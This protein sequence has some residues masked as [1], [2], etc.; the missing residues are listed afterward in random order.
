MRY[1]ILA[2]DYDGTL[3]ES[4]KV[5]PRTLAAL[6]RVRDSGR[7]LLLVTG[8]QIGDLQ[9]VFPELRLF[10]RIVAE[11]GALLY[12]PAT[13]EERLLTDPPPQEFV[14]VLESRGVV[15]LS[16]GRVVVATHKPH[17]VVALKVIRDM[18]LGLQI[19]FNKDAVMVLP[20]GVDKGS[21]L[22]H[23]LS[24]LRLSAHNT[25]G[26]GDA[27]NDHAFLNLCECAAA[28]GNAVPVIKKHV[29]FVVEGT[30]GEGVVELV[31]QLLQDDLVRF[32]SRLTRHHILFGSNEDNESVALP[33]F[34]RNVMI[35]GTS[36]GGKSTM[37]L[38]LLERLAN[39][40]YQYCIFDP[41]GD[42]ADLDNTVVLGDHQRPP[43]P[44]EVLDVL[45]EPTQDTVINLMG[46]SIEHRPDF[47]MG[48]LRRIQAL[49]DETG[50]PHWLLIDE[51]HHLL[52][53]TR[54]MAG[55]SFMK[56]MLMITV[57][58]D[59]VSLGALSTVDI[60]V[61]IGDAAR[62]TIHKFAHA[63]S[64]SAPEIP[65]KSIEP[66]EAMIWLDRSHDRAVWA[67][68][69]PP[70]IEKK[71]HVRKYMDGELAAE[72]CFYFTGPEQNLNLRAHNLHIFMQLAEGVDDATWSYHLERGDYA[73]WFRQSIKDEDLAREIEGIDVSLSPRDSRA[74]VK[75]KIEE[76]YTA[77]E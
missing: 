61:A 35:A 66:G 64:R 6:K 77:P 25:V 60:L 50:R 13:Q 18:G 72:E 38:G 53:A 28:V 14:N 44:H 19:I 1:H 45:S 9:R 15:R 46:I 17:E 26:I 76:R 10:E 49:R 31:E 34:G 39:Q 7:K 71:R 32:E 58:P 73:K 29:D 70:T 69:A 21:G 27:E 47:F 51:A 3:A 5:S 2:C 24:E 8:R 74:L 22:K 75:A 67:R 33:A 36:G 62:E 52:P 59:R 65:K 55:E 16:H 23:A 63:V 41:E 12:T 4:G 40:R 48:L 56:G 11:N 54:P 43:N 37:A 20:T 30:Y 68:S 42:Y 57:H